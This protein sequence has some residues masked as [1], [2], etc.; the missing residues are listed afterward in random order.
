MKIAKGT[1]EQVRNNA[2]KEG[3]NRLQ[4]S[5]QI[6]CGP[7]HC[8]VTS[9]KRPRN[10]MIMGKFHQSLATQFS[11][12]FYSLTHSARTL[13][14]LTIST[15]QTF[16]FQKKIPRCQTVGYRLKECDDKQ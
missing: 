13:T 8:N 16:P 6:I 14:A 1:I 5:P 2:H 9:E 4:E 3:I 12:L 10:T 7:E 11:N 15:T